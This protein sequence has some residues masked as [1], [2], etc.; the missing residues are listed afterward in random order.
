MGQAAL[1]VAVLS[2]RFVIGSSVERWAQSL[3]TSIRDEH[4]LVGKRLQSSSQ[5]LEKMRTI[6][7]YS[8]PDANVEDPAI[9]VAFAEKQKTS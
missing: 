6:F 9:Q 3:Y 7:G 2:M 8:D 1:V 4:F 5:G